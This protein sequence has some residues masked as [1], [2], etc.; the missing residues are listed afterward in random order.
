VLGSYAV[1]HGRRD[2]TVGVDNAVVT[3][4]VF[5]SVV[6]DNGC[7]ARELGPASDFAVG[8]GSLSVF[9]SATATLESTLAVCVDTLAL[10]LGFFVGFVVSASAFELV[11]APPVLTTTPV[12]ASDVSGPFGCSVLVDSDAVVDDDDSDVD[13]VDSEDGESEV[14]AD[15][16]AHP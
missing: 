13:D 1:G 15:A 7:A 9:T 16:V 3:A 11:C 5:G 14:S 6:D 4:A 10:G 2:G 12:G 8:C